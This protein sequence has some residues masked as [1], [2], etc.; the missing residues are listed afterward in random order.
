M[1]IYN[2]FVFTVAFLLYLDYVVHKNDV[3]LVNGGARL[4]FGNSFMYLALGLIIF[5][6][7]FRFEI[8]Y[9]Y[10]KYLAGYLYDSELKHWEPFFN[11]FVRLSRDINF[12][13][14]IQFMFLFFSAFTVLVMYKAI[15]SF[16]PHYR[17]G[18][19]LYVLIPALYLNTFSVLR[20]GVALA[21]LFYGLQYIV[22]EKPEYK[23]YILVSFVAFM[24]HYS[25]IFIALFY[26]L[27]AKFLG[28]LYSWVAYTFLIFAS[29]FLSV[30][31]VS[32]TILS[33]MPGHFSVYANMEN[34]VSI[35]KLLI[36]NFF[37]LF[38]M[39][40]KDT[41]IKSKLEKYLL[42][43][44]FMGLLIFNTFSDFIYVSRL[45]QYLL[46]AEIVL[47]P[48]YLYSIKDSLIRKG[49]FVIFL[50]Y[51]LFNF[52]YALYRDQNYPGARPHFL[53]PYENYL[54][55]EKKSYRNTNI[56]AWYNY[57]LEATE[58][59]QQESIK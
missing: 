16:S 38:F 42:N 43:S 9:D 7:G 30:A 32:K 14:D 36:I 1:L 57:I 51:Y 3:H 20:Q 37:F 47:V 2:L 4:S 8:G 25:S 31:H 5:F 55:E 19:L 13:L 33:M 6:A 39:I 15:K 34:E 21:I 49:M 28:R 35:L 11:F 24:F 58:E 44:I 48:I 53:V 59:Q 18:L 40:Q 45:G 12:G 29:L 56:E 23:K 46:V 54:F 41:F 26:L 22:K 52:D 10:P 50:F 17:L 27:S